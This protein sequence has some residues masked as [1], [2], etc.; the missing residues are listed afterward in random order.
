MSKQYKNTKWLTIGELEEFAK[1]RPE[2]WGNSNYLFHPENG[3]VVPNRGDCNHCNYCEAEETYNC[4]NV[5]YEID[6]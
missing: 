2:I 5:L 4:Q 1:E 3:M 6:Y